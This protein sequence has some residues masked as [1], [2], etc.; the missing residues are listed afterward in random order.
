MREREGGASV[1]LHPAGEA[2]GFG[3]FRFDRANRI[4]S[5]EG[6]ELPLPPRVLGVLEHLVARP[7][8]VVSKQALM[9]A[10]WKDAYATET[11]LTEAVSQLRQALGDDPQQPAYVQTVHRRGYRFVAPV[12]LDATPG[13]PVLRRAERPATAMV[14][15]AD[16]A[17]VE[18]GPADDGAS[19][20]TVGVVGSAAARPPARSLPLGVLAALAIATAGLLTL[21]VARGTRSAAVPVTRTAIPIAVGDPDLMRSPPALAFAPDG[22]TLVYAL[23]RGGRGQIF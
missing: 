10:V 8:S 1:V 21:T 23:A 14:S 17:A 16:P 7:G 18:G 9:A 12:T 20:Q 22:T 3:P 2:V 15:A 11:S 5:R 4:L 19:V 13:P 6:V